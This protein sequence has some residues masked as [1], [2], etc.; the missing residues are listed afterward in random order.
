[1]LP[2]NLAKVR[3]L[4]FGISWRKCRRKRNILRF[5]N[6]HP[7]LMHLTY[8]RTCCFNFLFLLNIFVN[9]RR[10]YLNKC[11]EL[12]QRFLHVW[13]GIDQTIIDTSSNY[14]DN[15]QH[16]KIRFCFLSNVTRFCDSFFGNY[17]N[18][19]LLSQGSAATYWRFGG[20]YYMD[21]VGN[22]LGFP[23]VQ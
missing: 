1:M 6:T 13:H 3:S 18:F 20:K 23:A 17:H 2:H 5:L 10:F 9:S 14:C 19:I 21:F 11:C 8:L 7:I 15:I 12:K 22:L 16:D 4:S